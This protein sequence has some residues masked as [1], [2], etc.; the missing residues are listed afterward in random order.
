MPQRSPKYSTERLREIMSLLKITQLEL[1][2]ELGMRQPSLSN[3]LTGK[4][5]DVSIGIREHLRNKYSVNTDYL[6]GLTDEPFINDSKV[7]LQ[8]KITK[9]ENELKKANQIIDL[10]FN[11]IERLNKN[12]NKKKKAQK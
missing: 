8:K 2:E 1:A 10:Q 7:I 9:L 5:K 6:Y 11:E 4:T 12:V 3:I